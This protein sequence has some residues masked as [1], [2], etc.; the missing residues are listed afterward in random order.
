MNV[1]II[2]LGNV[3]MS[4]DGFGPF[5]VRL[6]DALYQLPDGVEVVDA[7][8]PGLDLTPFLLDAD[9]VIFLDTVKSGRAPGTIHVFD[10]DEILAQRPVPRLSPHDPSLKDALLTVEAAGA[11]PSRVLLIGVVPASVAVGVELT[12]PVH[13]AVA[14]AIGLAVS[15]LDRLG[16]VPRRRPV[17]LPPDTWWTGGGSYAGSIVR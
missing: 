1:R 3:L 17:P 4:D 11:G 8:T 14:P 13:E 2:G 10:R 7:G 12:A 6:L 5:A 9:A 16:V 15:E